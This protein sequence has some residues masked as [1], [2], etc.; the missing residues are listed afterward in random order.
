MDLI[1][2]TPSYPNTGTFRELGQWISTRVK[3]ARLREKMLTLLLPSVRLLL[4]EDVKSRDW[5]RRGEAWTRFGL[6][7]MFVTVPNLPI[8]PQVP[9]MLKKWHVD[10]SLRRAQAIEE[11]ERLKLVLS[12]GIELEDDEELSHNDV[13][14]LQVAK[15]ECERLGT[16]LRSMKPSRYRPI[17]VKFRDVFVSLRA[18]MKDFG[19]EKRVLSLAKR[20]Y[21]NVAMSQEEAHWQQSTAKFIE[22]MS[23]NFELPYCDVVTPVRIVCHITS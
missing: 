22:S 12:G 9:D 23:Q 1:I 6:F 15:R 19:N 14:E 16:E 7:Q 21:D 5:K 20:L 18:Y 11:I 2:L 13:T 10:R 17:D 4:E 3:N 8:D